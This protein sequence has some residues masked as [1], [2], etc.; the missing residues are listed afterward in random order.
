MKP[1][2]VIWLPTSLLLPLSAACCYCH[3]MAELDLVFC[4][5]SSMHV[6]Q[7]LCLLH[8]SSLL[9]ALLLCIALNMLFVSL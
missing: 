2:K 3:G 8:S 9:T 5:V 6:L 1:N 7:E 4:S